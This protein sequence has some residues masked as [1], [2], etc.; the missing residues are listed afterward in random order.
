M[1]IKLS[2]ENNWIR[3]SS[4]DNL[5]NDPVS[6]GCWFYLDFCC[7]LKLIF[8]SLSVCLAS[9][10]KSKSKLEDAGFSKYCFGV[11]DA[12]AWF[13]DFRKY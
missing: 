9:S 4:K 1:H 5:C 7:L 12:L 13:E 6:L 10:M 3:W 11:A 8:D 2:F